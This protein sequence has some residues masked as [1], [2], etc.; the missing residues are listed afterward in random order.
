M[1]NHGDQY[2]VARLADRAAIYDTLCRGCRA[3]DRGD[4]DAIADIY[5]PDGIDHHGGEG[6]SRSPKDLSAW[7]KGRHGKIPFS[8]HMIGNVLIEFTGPDEAAVETYCL[9]FQR[10]PADARENLAALMGDMPVSDTNPTDLVIAA[11]YAD[12]FV[13]RNGEWKILERTIVYDSSMLI[14]AAGLEPFAISGL[15]RGTRNMDD[16]AYRMRTSLGL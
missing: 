16:P 7:V 5:H 15:A 12:H 1:T 9:A 10:Y 11:R 8:K 4:Y 13:R 3:V 2:S 6:G 14:E